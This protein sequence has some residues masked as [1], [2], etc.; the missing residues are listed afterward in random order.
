MRARAGITS[1]HDLEAAPGAADKPIRIPAEHSPPTRRQRR[2]QLAL[3]G[4]ALLLL[5]TAFAAAGV[6]AVRVSPGEIAAVLGQR[7]GLIEG[8]QLDQGLEA[9]VWV[10][11]LPRVLL[12][13]LVGAALAIAGVLLQGLFRNPLADPGLLGISSGAALAAAV[14]TVAESSLGGLRAL[15]GPALL[16]LAAFLGALIATTVV[17]RIASSRGRTDV[18]TLLLAGVALTSLA[19]AVTGLLTFFSTENQLRTI[20]NWRMGSLGGASWLASL[21]VAIPITILLLSAGRFGR[22]LDAILLGE[23]EARHL[24]VEVE[25][26]KRWIVFAA[27][28]IAGAAVAASGTVGFIGLVVPNL[29]RLIVGPGHRYLLPASALGGAA[30][31]LGADL[32][33][34]TIVSPAELPIGIVTAAIGAPFFL[35]LLLRHK[36]RIA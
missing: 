10:I 6:G 27:A 19:E 17:K 34:R 18:T 8:A 14:A 35:F 13:G 36:R 12:G 7:L 33:A 9:I 26:L 22:S 21:W 4:L 24:G 32:V 29:M 31:V 30:L 16:P 2:G 11:R 1:A 5:V 20:S 28:L 25:R 3:L 23:R 15:L